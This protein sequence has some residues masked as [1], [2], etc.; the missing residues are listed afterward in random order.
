MSTEVYHAA[1]SGSVAGINNLVAISQSYVRTVVS[2][3]LGNKYSSRVD[4]DD[5]C[6]DVLVKVATDVAHCEA[7]DWK[8]YLGWLA[9]V[10]RNTVYNTVKKMQRLKDSADRTTE[11]DSASTFGGEL[12]EASIEARESAAAFLNLA[13]AISDNTRVVVE[14]LLEGNDAEDISTATGLTK[15]AVHC[16]VSRFRKQATLLVS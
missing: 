7:E 13:S 15:A 16:I 5:V 3:Y 4:V 11:F 2:G 1:K 14:M 12:P 10:A 9:T 8:G 6:Q